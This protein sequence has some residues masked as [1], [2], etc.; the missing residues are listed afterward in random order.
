M[1]TRF[2]HFLGKYKNKFR[3]YVANS[4][5]LRQIIQLIL[6]LFSLA[7]IIGPIVLLVFEYKKSPSKRLIILGFL[8]AAIATF[9]S[10]CVALW[11]WRFTH[12]PRDDNQQVIPW[13]RSGS[14][15]SSVGPTQTQLAA[16]PSN[17]HG[18]DLSLRPITEQ[19]HSAATA[20]VNVDGVNHEG[21][22][23][24]MPSKI[25]YAGT[26]LA[27]DVRDREPTGIRGRSSVISGNVSG[28]WQ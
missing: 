6:F 2:R 23:A 22:N 4:V 15:S 7:A 9:F 18:M 24:T 27:G 8:S 10:C 20:E 14:E 19:A 5:N 11:W 21:N 16:E 17:T 26:C 12:P 1:T 28:R 3:Y 25:G 13:S